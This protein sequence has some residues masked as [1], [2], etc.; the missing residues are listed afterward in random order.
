MKGGS[1]CCPSQN[2][3][4]AFIHRPSANIFPIIL[5][6]STA[7]TSDYSLPQ[8]YHFNLFLNTSYYGLGLWLPP[9]SLVR[10]E[11]HCTTASLMLVIT[12]VLHFYSMLKMAYLSRPKS[13]VIS[14]SITQSRGVSAL[15]LSRVEPTCDV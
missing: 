4:C 13:S 2:G 14:L 10:E 9:V 3:W 7:L 12:G 6:K 1:P 8:H 5:N 15:I 11:N